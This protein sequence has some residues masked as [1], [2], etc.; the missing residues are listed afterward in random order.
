MKTRWGLITLLFAVGLMAAMQFIKVSLTLD[1]LAA[2]YGR[3]LEVVSFFVSLVSL[4]GVALGVVAGAF[5]AKLGTRRVILGALALGA[6]VSA[7][8]AFLPPFWLMVPLRALEGLSHL[9]LVV[10]VPPTMAAVSLPKD[11]PVVMSIWAMFFGVAFSLAALLFPPLLAMGGIPALF[12]AHGAA[13]LALGLALIFLLPLSDAEDRPIHFVAAHV[14]AYRSA[15]LAGPGLVFLFYTMLFVA[16]VTFLPQIL[17]RPDLAVSLPLISLA[18]TFAGGWL[19][20]SL[21]PRH[22]MMLGYGILLGSGAVLMWGGI[23]AVYPMFI[24]MGLVPGAC[25]A[26]IPAWNVTSGAQAR[27]TG[28]IAQLG[29]VGTGTGTPLFAFAIALTGA[30]GLWGLLVVLPLA[31]LVMAIWVSRRLTS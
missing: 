30:P 17:E 3:S 12:F 29:N 28:A 5:V 13:F 19:C 9:A 10:A 25:F 7:L 23:W 8:G 16:T 20:R 2:H 4:V 24:G 26:A 27:A 15:S 14:E 11:R 6:I 31:G 18:G 22:V 1:A 21:E